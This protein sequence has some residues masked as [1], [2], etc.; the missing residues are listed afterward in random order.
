MA[1]KFCWDGLRVPRVRVAHS[2][3]SQCWDQWLS[4]TRRL[5]LCGASTL[6]EEAKQQL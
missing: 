1:R 3:R 2:L 4:Y 6:E 5:W